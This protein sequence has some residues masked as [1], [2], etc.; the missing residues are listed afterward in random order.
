VLQEVPAKREQAA[1][2]VEEA[3]RMRNDAYWRRFRLN[4]W[5][6]E[7]GD[8]YLD[9][10][11]Y[12]ACEVEPIGEDKLAGAECYVGLDKSGGAWD[13]TGLTALF[14][15]EGGR[16]YERHWT[17]AHADRIADMAERDDLDYSPY[18][19]AGELVLIPAE[20]VADEWL[21]EWA[22]ATFANYR[23]KQIA[24]D[25]YGAAYLLER[26][27]ADGHEVV[28]VQQSNNRLLSPV[29]QD[30]AERVQQGR[31]VH[32]PNGLVSWQVACTRAITTAKD[33]KKLV[34]AGSSAKGSGGTGHID[35][36]DAL[37]N[38]LAA[39]RAVEIETAAYGASGGA[40]VG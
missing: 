13:F 10:E 36:V 4:Q 2:E 16:V 27:K 8:A 22:T 32:P 18:V 34:K 28:A 20:A 7:D 17:F 12:A 31:S 39:L 9:G 14:P 23:V 29:I 30:Y 35:N 21:Y 37:I 5:I 1:K 33:C 40:V 19:E 11:V 15:M 26:W 6:S 24:G 25:P 38:A 3:R